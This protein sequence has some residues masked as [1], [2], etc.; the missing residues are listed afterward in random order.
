MDEEL[1][2]IANELG[3]NAVRI[4]GDNDELLLKCGLIALT[5][6]FDSVALAPRYIDSTIDE[7][8]QKVADFAGKAENLRESSSKVQL[9]VGNE[10]TID[11]SG[12]REGATYNERAAANDPPNMPRALNGFLRDL[13]SA[14]REE[15]H[16]K[17]SY[18]AGFWEPVDWN[19]IGADIVG[20]NEYFWPERDNINEKIVSLEKHG[21]P[22][23]ITE[24][25]SSTF[26]GACQWGGG[27]FFHYNGAPYDEDTQANC[28][29]NYLKIFNQTK[30]D[31]CFL[32]E[33]REQDAQFMGIVTP[34][35]IG[36]SKRKKSFY[37]YKSYQRAS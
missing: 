17:L 22:V 7:T 13:I 34:P 4:F 20:S 37:M 16:G 10:L 8:I 2:V 6:A 1:G 32:W 24:F 26:K 9:W 18:S 23:Y 5:K 19:Q 15:F 25:G 28:I 36:S 14:S 11:A 27:G 33:Y 31:G 30:P 35:E 12:I 3:C 21:K 29:E